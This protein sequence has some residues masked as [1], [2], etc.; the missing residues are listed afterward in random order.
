MTAPQTRLLPAEVR[1]PGRQ[2]APET[3]LQMIE[4]HL[5]GVGAELT[6]AGADY[7]ALWPHD[8]NADEAVYR[9]EH[10]NRELLD[11]PDPRVREIARANLADCAIY[12]R[13]DTHEDDRIKLMRYRER[14]AHFEARAG[15]ACVEQAETGVM[16]HRPV[17]RQ[18][19]VAQPSLEG[20]T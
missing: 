2:I 7:D 14:R 12:R 17:R 1:R 8:T 11:H 19:P 5:Y 16:R 3:A 10:R 9:Q 15:A 20:M 6:Y 18:P 13:E 4:G